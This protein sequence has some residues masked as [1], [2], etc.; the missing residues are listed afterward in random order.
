MT[1]EIEYDDF[2]KIDLRIG[3]ILEAINVEGADKL[4]KLKVNLGDLG[5][6]E[7]FA[8]I[9]KS[10]KPEDLI[11]MKTIVV[12]NLKPKTMKFGTSSAMVLAVSSDGEI[13]VIEADSKIKNGS[14]VK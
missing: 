9:K 4:L 10:Y 6:K 8:G 2:S 7:I 11:G 3:E 1:N 14:K 12:A 5:D 13:I